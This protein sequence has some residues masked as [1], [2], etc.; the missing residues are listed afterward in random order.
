V[1]LLRLPNIRGTMSEVIRSELLA[2]APRILDDL[3][4]A[5]ESESDPRVNRLL[6]QIIAESRLP[7]AVPVLGRNFYN[8][9][10]SVCGWCITALRAIGTEEARQALVDNGWS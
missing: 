1:E 3:V 9:D 5:F 4:R 10:G 7:E 6:L 2:R 8:A